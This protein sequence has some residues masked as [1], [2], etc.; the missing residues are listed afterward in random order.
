MP[1]DDPQVRGNHVALPLPQ[2][3]HRLLEQAEALGPLRLPGLSEDDLGKPGMTPAVRILLATDDQ[4]V[5]IQV[6]RGIENDDAG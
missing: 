6:V 1:P 3:V 2:D 4:E 5:L